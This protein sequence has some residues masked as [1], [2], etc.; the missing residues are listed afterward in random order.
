MSRV[1]PIG[2]LALLALTLTLGGCTFIK[3][4]PGGERVRILEAHEIGNCERI[5]STSASVAEQVGI[6][7]R[8]PEKLTQEVEHAARNAAAEMGGDTLVPQGPLREGR[9]GYDVYRCI[10]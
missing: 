7:R 6:F 10:R 8:P 2:T 9:R 1:L 3:L 4:T 5:G